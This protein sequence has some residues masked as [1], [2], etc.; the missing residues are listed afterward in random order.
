METTPTPWR[1]EG[2]MVDGYA[3]IDADNRAVISQRVPSTT[4]NRIVQAVNAHDALVAALAQIIGAADDPDNERDSDF[5]D[6]VDWMA[7]RAALA[8]A[9]GT[10]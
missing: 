10:E 1:R 7:A 2:G 5:S 9:K 4:A 6:A 3:I 8:L